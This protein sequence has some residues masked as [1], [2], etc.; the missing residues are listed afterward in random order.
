M[1]MQFSVTFYVV[2]KY[3]MKESKAG[4]IIGRGFGILF[5]AMFVIAVIALV[6]EGTTIKK[7]IEFTS[8]IYL[9]INQEGPR[10]GGDSILYLEVQGPDSGFVTPLATAWECADGY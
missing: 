4:K 5:M 2:T 1:R 8:T 10:F 3:I 7:P 6:S 9:D